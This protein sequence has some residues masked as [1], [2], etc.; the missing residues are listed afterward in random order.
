MRKLL[1]YLLVSIIVSALCFY[2]DIKL[3]AAEQGEMA[4][5]INAKLKGGEDFVLSDLR[6]DYVLLN[7]WGSWCG[8]CR[9]EHPQLLDISNKYSNRVII[10]T[11]GLE[12]T[13]DNGVSA[14]K[15]DGFLWKNQIIEESSLLLMSGVARDYGV[16]SI[17]SSFLISPRG[18]ILE[19]RSL[20][21]IEKFLSEL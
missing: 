20:D 18:R 4:P 17:P 3:N 9:A 10:V 21:E 16:S 5:E 2:A 19:P 8:P 6:G 1:Y 15:A 13:A 7:F 12:K 11:Y 14:A